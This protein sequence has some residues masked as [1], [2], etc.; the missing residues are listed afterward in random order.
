VRVD[1][2]CPSEKRAHFHENGRIFPSEMIPSKLSVALLLIVIIFAVP[3]L[4]LSRI[5]CNNV[6]Q[7]MDVTGN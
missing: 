5:A 2:D 3:C 6:K 7:G 4:S 1:A